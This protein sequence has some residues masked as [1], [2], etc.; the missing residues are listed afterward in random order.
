MGKMDLWWVDFSNHKTGG[1]AMDM[2]WIKNWKRNRLLGLIPHI[3][4]ELKEEIQKDPELID[5]LIASAKKDP[6][7]MKLLKE[8]GISLP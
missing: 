6:E 3:K 4:D 1:I 7:V 5:S 8:R 2:K